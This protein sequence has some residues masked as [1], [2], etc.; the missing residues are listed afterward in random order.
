MR[1][2]SL[3]QECLHHLTQTFG[4]K[5]Y[6]PGQKAA[7]HA[8]LSGRDV[9][10]ILPTGAGKSLCWQLP[11]LVHPG[12]TL[13]VSPLIALMRDQVQHL[14]ML[15]IPVAS[16]DSL[17][18]AQERERAFA[19]IRSGEVRI[20]FA[21]PERLE[22]PAFRQ[23]CKTVPPWLIVVDE[24]HCIVQW[25]ES[26]R[27]AYNGICA[28]IRMLPKRP[29]VCALTATAD[30]SMQKDVTAALRMRRL[31]RILL[32]ILRENLAYTVRTTLD[33]TGEILRLYHTNPC[34]T[35]VFC[36]TRA[37]CEHLVEMIEKQGIRADYYHA[38]MERS[39]RLSVQQR[40]HEGNVEVL[41]ATTA[42]G[43][44]VDIP[45][46]R[47][48]IHDFIPDTLID[49]V[50]QSG[51]GGR[52]GQKAE[53]VLLF[54]PNDVVRKA[55]IAKHAKAK[56]RWQLLRR[57]LYVYRFWRIQ[58]KLLRVL[59]TAPCIPAGITEAFGK[60]AK[61]CGRCSACLHGTNQKHIPSLA[62]MQAW[63]IRAWLLTW[64][65]D[66]LAEKRGVPPK[67]I[68]TDHSLNTAARALIFPPDASVPEE[69]RRLLTH[70]REVG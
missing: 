53:C 47:R 6:R 22:Q 65:R 60:R 27:P 42:F 21:S 19:R 64:Q 30:R 70:F 61:P 69:L 55:S 10:C 41:C 33:R 28:F 2:R 18:D 8:L 54:D 58:M 49:Y 66:A 34:K 39:E 17:M 31:R 51:R 63:Q 67:T 15:G 29:V 59:L 13:V 14:A 5:A 57:R 50:Q 32:P 26:F 25:G 1:K 62:G 16:I 43:M 40:F 46:I 24:A 38:G 45:D 12:L 9:L 20:V 35:L 37:R 68:I 3:K 7:V 44:G 52:D 23:L 11:A 4:L 56:Y 48:V 36:R